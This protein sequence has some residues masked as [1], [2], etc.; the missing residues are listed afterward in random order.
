MAMSQIRV[1]GP[2]H[3]AFHLL[4]IKSLSFA[5]SFWRRLQTWWLKVAPIEILDFI[6]RCKLWNMNWVHH[7]CETST[8]FDDLPQE[9][10]ES[11]CEH[12][13][14]LSSQA[15]TMPKHVRLFPARC[16]WYL[17]GRATNVPV[18]S[19]NCMFCSIL[20][21]PE[22]RQ[23]LESEDLGGCRFWEFYKSS[24]RLCTEERSHWKTAPV[25]NRHAL[26]YGCHYTP[27]EGGGS[28]S[29]FGYGP[30]LHPLIHVIISY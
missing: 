11:H 27:F 7:K 23:N 17:R 1:S 20:A 10:V 3:F 12:R 19:F 15:V 26:L 9:K 13:C 5:S 6:W 22:N 30:S 14:L 28:S 2:R 29:T 21:C 4:Y 25:K 18:G 24:K 8:K 16:A